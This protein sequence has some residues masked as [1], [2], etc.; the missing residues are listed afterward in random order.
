[1]NGLSGKMVFFEQFLRVYIHFRPG[2][3]STGYDRIPV[4]YQAE[5]GLLTEFQGFS[6]IVSLIP[7][8]GTFKIS[9][10][11]GFIQPEEVRRL[12]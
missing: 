10:T 8:P 6:Q 2:W 11:P 7:L 12:K 5:F 9:Q 1:M 4:D 3:K